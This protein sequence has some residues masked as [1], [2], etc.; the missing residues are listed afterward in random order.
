[1]ADIIPFRPGFA[2]HSDRILVAV[3]HGIAA[4]EESRGADAL[5]LIASIAEMACD[6]ALPM[7]LRREAVRAVRELAER[8]LAVD[9]D[10]APAKS[11]AGD[12]R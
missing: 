8:A 9:L 10:P 3:S 2:D 6:D 1:M 4:I 12:V 7:R 11:A 5:R